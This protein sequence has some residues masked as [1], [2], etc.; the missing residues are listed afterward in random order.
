M[1]R[2][3][4]MLLLVVSGV[5]A[6]A[7]ISIGPWQPL[8]QGVDFSECG[9]DGGTVRTQR[10]FALRVNLAAGNIEFFS[11]PSN[12]AAPLETLGQT[13][14][15]FVDTCRVSV[16]VNANFFSPVGI[17]QDEPREIDGLAVSKGMVVSAGSPKRPAAR[18][19]RRN[20]VTF[21]DGASGVPRDC[22]TA[23]A[24]S[25]RILR[26]GTNAVDADC[27]TS[28][29]KPNPRTALGLSRDKRH[30]YMMVIDGRQPGWSDGA[31][32]RETADWLLRFGAW[33]GLNLDG[34]GSSA[35]AWSSNGVAVLL[36]RPSS[37]VQRVN[38]NHIG[39]FA[40]PLPQG[41]NAASAA[42]PKPGS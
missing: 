15:A 3:I 41:T 9:A 26:N 38:G 28:F 17:R 14:T 29:C 42:R 34:G 7:E 6:S 39:V 37:G 4:V 33:E 5:S 32:L 12:G 22:W 20:K 31:T 19:S 2:R 8:F 35:M 23:V 24:G 13:T 1:L 18:I 27:A 36:N 10:V 25:H 16:A 11:T 30:L 21:A 40:P